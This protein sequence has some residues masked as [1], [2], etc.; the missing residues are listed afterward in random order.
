MALT[1]QYLKDNLAGIAQQSELVSIQELLLSKKSNYIESIITFNG[2]F[3]FK[4][5]DPLFDLR[6]YIYALQRNEQNRRGPH[7]LQAITRLMKGRELE[8]VSKD[9]HFVQVDCLKLNSDNF[10]DGVATM[11]GVTASM[12]ITGH[13]FY[14]PTFKIND[15]IRCEGYLNMLEF[16]SGYWFRVRANLEGNILRLWAIEEGDDD[17][18]NPFQTLDL[19]LWASVS[20][21]KT[22][23]TLVP[24]SKCERDNTFELSRIYFEYLDKDEA[25]QLPLQYWF[26]ADSADDARRWCRRLN[27]MLDLVAFWSPLY[28]NFKTLH[29]KVFA[30]PDNGCIEVANDKNEKH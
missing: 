3:V 28:V 1:Q 11:V 20:I 26:S 2:D 30:G 5:V 7:A 24:K 13:F 14:I 29:K 23:V 9:L 4:D 19:E 27:Q 18:Q 10:C 16:E 12:P 17:S 25:E 21:V 22:P 6:V 15:D 8:G